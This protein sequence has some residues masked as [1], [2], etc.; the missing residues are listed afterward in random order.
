MGVT[1]IYVTHDQIEAMTMGDRVAVM[2][3]GVLQQVADPH[4]LYD[5]PVNLFVAGFIGRPDEHGRGDDRRARRAASRVEFGDQ[6]FVLDR[7]G[8]SRTGR[9]LRG[10]VGK[11]VAV[12]VRSEDLSEPGAAQRGARRTVGCVRR[13]CS[14]RRWARR[15]SST[16]ASPPRR[17]RP[18]RPRSLSRGLGHGRHDRQSVEVPARKF[19]A[20]FS[21]RSQVKPGDPIEVGVDTSRLY[22]FDLETGLAIRS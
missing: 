16:S 2:R 7:R 5:D 1:T 11:T 10:Y 8:R 19:V 3:K 4:E 20:S 15:S 6:R 22:F 13:R 18:R 14:R 12:G 17:S 21:P 9:R